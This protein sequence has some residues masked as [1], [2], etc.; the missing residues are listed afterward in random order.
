MSRNT[1]TSQTPF[2]SQFGHITTILDSRASP[3][4]LVSAKVNRPRLHFGRP[5]YPK[6][7]MTHLKNKQNITRKSTTLSIISYHNQH[8]GTRFGTVSVSALQLYA[9]E[10]GK[11]NWINQPPKPLGTML[12]SG[13][14]VFVGTVVRLRQLQN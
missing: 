10:F 13:I 11:L 8:V 4:K 9:N 3:C 14:A 7:Y 6:G 1:K 2:R 5:R 12:S